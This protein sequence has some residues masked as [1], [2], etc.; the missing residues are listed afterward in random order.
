MELF[1]PGVARLP[2][3]QCQLMMHDMRTG[4]PVMRPVGPQKTPTPITA[5][6][7]GHRA[8]CRDAMYKCPK[9]T[10][11]TARDNMLNYRNRRTV[12]LYIHARATG[13]RFVPQFDALMADNF[14]I[15]HDLFAEYDRSRQ[16]ETAVQGMGSLIAALRKG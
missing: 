3:S 4:E 9:G 10:P 15:M 1:H 2:C 8:P 12:T 6:D 14:A 5:K 7:N 16:A 13:F 11:E